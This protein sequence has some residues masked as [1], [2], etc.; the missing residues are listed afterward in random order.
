MLRANSKFN[1]IPFI[2]MC[3]KEEL[4]QL[5]SSELQ[6]TEGYVEKPIDFD[7][8]NIVMNEKVEQFRRYLSSL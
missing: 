1:Y 3:Q 6:P 8:L 4:V 2:L 5:K 7:N